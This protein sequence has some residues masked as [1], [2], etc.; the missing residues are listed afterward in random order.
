MPTSRNGT[1]LTTTTR[2]LLLPIWLAAGLAQAQSTV[3]L[4]GENLTLSELQRIGDGAAVDLA[5][6]SME[7]VRR[8]H[9]LLMQ[10]AA[11]GRTVYGLTVGVGWNKDRPVFETVDGEKVVSDALLQR[12]R[13]FNIAALRSHGAGVGEPMPVPTTRVS[14]AIRLNQLLTGA[15]AVQP[16]VAE[17][18]MALLNRDVTPVVPGSGTIGQ[19]DITLASHVGLAMI[20]EWQVFYEGERIAAAKALEAAGIEPLRP[21]G[22]DFLSILSNN[23]ITAAKATLATL[24]AERFLE[25]ETLVFALAL[26]G[27]NG[28]IAPF[29]P[30]TTSLRPYPGMQRAAADIRA[31]LDGSDLWRVSEDRP[32]QD[33][34]SYRTMAYRLGNA[35]RALSALHEALKL[36]I[37]SS[38]DNPA[39]V[40]GATT[41][42][43]QDQGQVAGYLVEGELNG[44]IY[45]TSNF[46]ALPFVAA[47]ERLSLA[48]AHVSMAM[49]QQTIRLS[50]PTFTNLTRFFRDADYNGLA[51]IYKPL[52][53][54]DA[55]IRALARPV[56]L[57][58]SVTSGNIEDIANNSGLAVDHL[59][60]IVDRLYS[61][62]SIQLLNAAQ[63]VGMRE[64]FQ[65]GQATERL[66]TAYREV[67]P[68][69]EVDR[70][71]T[72]DT[73]AGEEFLRGYEINEQP[74]VNYPS[75][76]ARTST[77]PPATS[78]PVSPAAPR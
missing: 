75:P 76:A 27:L 13:E 14:M 36:Q 49:T 7:R 11:Q 33:P 55:E 40:L 1:A 30:G 66:L 77:P 12:S 28:N 48:L 19:A 18:Y 35:W 71:Y 46:E 61:L 4:D 78:P 60:T 37:N 53:A 58:N 16:R 57:Y 70:N 23:S 68:F 62:S 45:P 54:L 41:V 38:D 42:P 17:L 47:T 73:K 51:P 34:L 67:V 2:W 29:L 52:T 65:Q 72:P 31:A 32:L 10:A 43:P 5:D 74:T 3:T 6:G 64:D 69:I 21:V 56:S 50:N 63:A 9:E 22:K 24:A 8:A 39:V 15:P 25:R 44:A 59:G 26:E 20:G